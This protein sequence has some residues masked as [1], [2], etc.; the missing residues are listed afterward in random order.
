MAENIFS[1]QIN[2]LDGIEA[3]LND[4]APKV[5]AQ[6]MR[7]AGRKAGQLYQGALEERAPVDA[8]AGDPHLADHIAVET[9]T[10]K[11][12]GQIQV[13][14]GPESDVYWGIF[15]EFGTHDQQA[16]PFM[17]PVFEENKDAATQVFVDE[18]QNGLEKFRQK[19]FVGQIVEGLK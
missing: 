19:E 9:H 13:S 14:V 16:Q 10:D 15:Q 8:S 11:G 7:T 18:V 4:V 2:G 12:E 6:I 3:A 5:A 17:R 1:V